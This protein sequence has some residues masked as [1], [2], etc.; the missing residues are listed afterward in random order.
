MKIEYENYIEELNNLIRTKNEECTQF[1]KTIKDL[2]RENSESQTN[3][4]KYKKELRE[5]QNELDNVKL[6]ENTDIKLNE[7]QNEI[8]NCK[9]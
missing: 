3:L 7:F 8:K 6:N 9:K 1:K 2:F 4:L 5:L